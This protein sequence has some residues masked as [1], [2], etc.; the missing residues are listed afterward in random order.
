MHFTAAMPLLAISTLLMTWCPPNRLTNSSGVATMKSLEPL[1]VYSRSSLDK[2]APDI[3]CLKSLARDRLRLS[4]SP[5]RCSVGLC[6]VSSPSSSEQSIVKR[7]RGAPPKPLVVG[8][9]LSSS[10]QGSTTMRTGLWTR[11]GPLVAASSS[12][13]SKSVR[14]TPFIATGVSG[15][16]WFDVTVVRTSPR[17][18]ASPARMAVLFPKRRIM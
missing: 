16:P 18:G 5:M 8:G 7:A 17:R 12:R 11:W 1:L 10:Q 13:R 6:C 15:G 4:S 2:C 9:G 14:S 3:D